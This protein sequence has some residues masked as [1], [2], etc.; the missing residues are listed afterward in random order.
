MRIGELPPC[1][2]SSPFLFL[3]NGWRSQFGSKSGRQ[4]RSRCT[5][6]LRTKTQGA[7]TRLTTYLYSD[8]FT[9]LSL[10][11]LYCSL[12]R[13]E[14]RRKRRRRGLTDSRTTRDYDP[15]RELHVASPNGSN[16]THKEGSR[17]LH[18]LSPSQVPSP[19][20]QASKLIVSAGPA[21]SEP[22]S[23]QCSE[24]LDWT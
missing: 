11:R 10:L 21:A 19:K 5:Y 2:V 7:I 9:S 22:A 3:E 13:K 15:K 4:G 16:S 23:L 14:E 1:L 12:R 24:V 17:L 8:L 6:K 18:A 20:S